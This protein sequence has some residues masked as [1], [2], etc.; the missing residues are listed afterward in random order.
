MLLIVRD[1][2]A[3]REN[4][5]KLSY[6]VINN[7]LYF[8]NNKRDLYLY[9]SSSIKEEVFKLI[10]NKI[11]YLEYIYTHK[12]LIKELYIFDIAIKLYKFIRYYLY[13]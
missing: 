2:K 9:I 13:Y 7:L 8:N 5:A 6:R 3:L 12:K 1:N 10:Y 11:R 4:A